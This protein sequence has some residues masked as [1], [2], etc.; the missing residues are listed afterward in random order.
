MDRQTFHG[1]LVF[2]LKKL[3]DPNESFF[4]S[5][6]AP[7]PETDPRHSAHSLRAREGNEVQFMRP[8][9]SGVEQPRHFLTGSRW[10]PPKR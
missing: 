10:W 3:V 2:G 4:R 9:R 7:H 1:F 6:F 5:L 8:Q